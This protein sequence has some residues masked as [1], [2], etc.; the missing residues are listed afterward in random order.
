MKI[1]V[2]SFAFAGATTVGLWYTLFMLAIKLRPFAT[3][4]F[5]SATHMI[6][7]LQNLAPYIKI[8]DTALI[9]GLAVHLV[10]A[11]LFFGLIAFLYNKLS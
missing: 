10:F 11:Y 3:L 1:K 8:T 5:I 2:H 6:P 4:K 7:N 9:A